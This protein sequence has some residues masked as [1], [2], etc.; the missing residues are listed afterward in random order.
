MRVKEI[1]I[2]E[3]EESEPAKRY[4]TD[5]EDAVLRQYYGRADTVKIAGY[6]K[7]TKRAVENRASIL[8]IT[9]QNQRVLQ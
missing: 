2:P 1:T 8:G 7:R 6:L 3:L 9:Y 5:E 4:W